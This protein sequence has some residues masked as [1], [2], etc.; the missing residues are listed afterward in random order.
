VRIERG[1]CAEDRLALERARSAY[2]AALH[3]SPAA[4][5]EGGTRLSKPPCGE[6]RRGWKR[7]VSDNSSRRRW[8]RSSRSA[9]TANSTMLFSSAAATATAAASRSAAAVGAP[10]AP[11]LGRMS[12][13]S[14]NCSAGSALRTCNR[15][16][17]RGTRAPETRLSEAEGSIHRDIK[18]P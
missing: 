3:C 11:F 1:R 13:P 15:C 4:Y 5:A 16:A 7:T 6:P 8:T 9:G 17:R 18:R 2:A 10:S 12:L 14:K